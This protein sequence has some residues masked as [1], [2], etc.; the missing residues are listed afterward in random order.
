MRSLPIEVRSAFACGQP[1]AQR[2][3]AWGLTHCVRESAH[4]PAL[5]ILVEEL[6]AY[7]PLDTHVVGG[8]Q[9]VDHARHLPMRAP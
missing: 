9:L 4:G 3:G 7:L 5:G 6:T 2:D 8:E 1:F